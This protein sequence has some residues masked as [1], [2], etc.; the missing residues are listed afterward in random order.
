MAGKYDYL[1]GE[2]FASGLLD[3]QFSQLQLLEDDN[4]GFVEEMVNLYFTDT[5][6]KLQ[7]LGQ[8]V[9]DSPPNLVE[10]DSTFHQLKGSS[11]SIGAAAVAIS[12]MD[13]RAQFQ[14]NDPAQTKMAYE[15]LEGSFNDL[16]SRLQP[17]MELK[18][19]AVAQ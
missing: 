5:A 8:L 10:L 6:I 3:G 18:R 2:L 7:R 12:C 13:C 1:L 11:A 15:R 4:P 9:S 14:K 19:Q 17:I 16:K